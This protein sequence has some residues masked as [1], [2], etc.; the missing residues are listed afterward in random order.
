MLASLLMALISLDDPLLPRCLAETPKAV[1]EPKV[2]RVIWEKDLKDGI[3]EGYEVRGRTNAID[4][5]RLRDDDAIV[6]DIFE[7]SDYSKHELIKIQVVDIEGRQYLDVSWLY[8]KKAGIEEWEF[9]QKVGNRLLIFEEIPGYKNYF[10]NFR[11][12]ATWGSGYVYFDKV[13]N[14]YS[15]TKDVLPST[16]GPRDSH[17][18]VTIHVDEVLDALISDHQFLRARVKDGPSIQNLDGHWLIKSRE[19]F[20]S[21]AWRS[22][23][24]VIVD[25]FGN[26]KEGR[27]TI[28]RRYLERYPSILTKDFKIDKELWGR[29]EVEIWL[30]RMK[31]TLDAWEHI[32]KQELVELGR[33]EVG[34]AVYYSINTC[35]HWLT[36]YVELPLGSDFDLMKPLEFEGSHRVHEEL[37]TW[38]KEYG[39][40]AYWDTKYQR[41]RTRYPRSE[42]PPE[43]R[44]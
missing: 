35:I 20:D 17:L 34:Q 7:N 38:W 1:Q 33:V 37:S 21:L 27:E 36:P 14:L 11:N 25:V 31:R 32:N 26:D 28:V 42:K 5:S 30:A 6:R 4:I 29:E 44:R 18:R 39:H 41:L 40:T 13:C 10:R 12:M 24:H 8:N 43:P 19:A 2:L 9:L 23:D 22:G 3:P 15:A 16:A